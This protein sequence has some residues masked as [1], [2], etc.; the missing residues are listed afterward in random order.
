M[1][2]SV[3][4]TAVSAF[5]IH[6]VLD[7]GWNLNR[8]IFE[9]QT[10]WDVSVIEWHRIRFLRATVHTATSW[11]WDGFWFLLSLISGRFKSVTKVK[12]VENNWLCWMP[13]NA[14]LHTWSVCTYVTTCI[15]IHQLELE[16]RVGSHSHPPAALTPGKDLVPFLQEGGWAPGP[17][18][19]GAENLAPIGIRSP[20]RPELQCDRPKITYPCIHNNRPDR[21]IQ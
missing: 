4:R 21:V 6:S 11:R 16:S 5:R 2:A 8:S 13:F 20:D 9:G 19:M 12:I 3:H 17:V 15:F 18:R 1:S 14:S 10:S 7:S